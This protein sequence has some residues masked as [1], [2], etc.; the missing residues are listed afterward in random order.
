MLKPLP[1]DAVHAHERK[2]PFTIDLDVVEGRLNLDFAVVEAAQSPLFGGGFVEPFE[3]FQHQIIVHIPVG[4]ERPPHPAD[5][6][7]QVLLKLLLLGR[8]AVGEHF[9][10]GERA[11]SVGIH[12]VG[13]GR[14]FQF[15]VAHGDDLLAAPV[16]QS[17]PATA[18]HQRGGS[19]RRRDVGVIEGRHHFVAAP[20]Q[21]PFALRPHPKQ[22]FGERTDFGET[23]F[24]Q[25][26][27]VQIE[28]RQG[29]TALRH[30]QILGQRQPVFR[31]RQTHHAPPRSLQGDRFRTPAQGVKIFV[32]LAVFVV[33]GGHYRFAR[34]GDGSPATS[35]P[36]KQQFVAQ[37]EPL[38]DGRQ[39]GLPTRC[40][41]AAA[42]LP[43]HAQQPLG[44][45][46]NAVELGW[47][48]GLPAFVH[49]TPTAATPVGEESVF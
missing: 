49:H 8:G 16:E 37:I 6:H 41:D 5:A 3:V 29:R 26:F 1:R 11:V 28:Q 33:G 48:H 21:P 9:V 40:E 35:F 32:D 14:A 31:T 43:F 22:P 44:E 42:P 27:V 17:R 23:G 7:R 13:F 15:V 47:Q 38:G 4:G 24:Q 30:D 45:I 39:D 2:A 12:L 18:A 20:H 34:A 10:D 36:K 19:A 25:D 46:R